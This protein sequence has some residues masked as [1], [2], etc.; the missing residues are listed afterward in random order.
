M[1]TKTVKIDY[2]YL[3]NET[4][5]RCKDTE[6][7]LDATLDEI[8]ELLNSAGYKSTLNKIKMDTREKARKYQFTKSPTIRIN[9]IDIG[10]EQKENKCSDCDDLCGCAE[11]TT[12]RTWLLDGQEYEVP[13]KELLTNRIM[14]VIY[15]NMKSK[16]QDFKLPEN[17]ESFYAGIEKER[18]NECCDP[19]CCS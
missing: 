9:D 13:P 4:C 6:K 2:L 17:L 11:G 18:K 5:T 1:D 15:G 12:C 8:D 7:Q 10:F 16:R 3:D 19:T 14:Q